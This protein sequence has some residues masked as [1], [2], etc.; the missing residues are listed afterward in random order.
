MDTRQTFQCTHASEH[1]SGQPRTVEVVA[2]TFPLWF[3]YE[4]CGFVYCL[5]DYG[6]CVRVLGTH[7]HTHTHTHT[8]AHTHTHGTAH[9]SR[10]AYE[11]ARGQQIKT[12]T[13]H[14]MHCSTERAQQGGSS[15]HRMHR[16]T[17]PKSPILAIPSSVS[18]VLSGLISLC[19]TLYW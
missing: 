4:G 15:M 2:A 11:R 6:C 18:S 13:A 5:F 16:H 12:G 1:G 10:L 7:I 14:C 19:M 3:E 8:R 17:Y 9:D